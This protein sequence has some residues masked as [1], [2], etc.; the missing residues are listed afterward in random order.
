MT[1]HVLKAV[2]LAG[3]LAPAGPL[4]AET[5]RLALVLTLDV[6]GSVD[7]EEDRLQREGL[8]GALLAPEVVR[9]FLTG[10]PVAIQ[11][12][13]WASNDSQAALLPGWQM[14]RNEQDL[15]EAA[16]IIAG[17]ERL[18]LLLQ[19][20]GTA[21]GDALAHAAEVLLEAPHCDAQTIDVAGDGVNN[22]GVGPEI[23][24][25]TNPRLDGVTVNA[26][27][28]GAAQDEHVLI[29]QE[30]LVA[31]FEDEVL[32]GPAAF[33]VLADGYEDY[34]RAMIVKLRRELEL[35]LVSGWLVSPGAG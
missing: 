10:E 2:T 3:F 32:H 8:A 31:W 26:L 17:A 19:R 12:F 16:N 13:E 15:V 33:W 28:V 25:A 22:D 24:Y 35:P 27:V 11:A 21:L 1:K 6:S 5:C 30:D 14:I 29:S 23:T 18:R 20:D 4:A 34:E 7:P 9:A